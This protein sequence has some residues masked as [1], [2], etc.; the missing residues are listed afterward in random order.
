M[1]S[2]LVVDDEFLLVDL[3]SFILEEEGYAVKRANHGKMALDMI[4]ADPP[5]LV[6]TDFMM[7]LMNGLELANRLKGD[8][9]FMDIPII[10]VTGAQGT[11]ARNHPEIFAAVFDKP[12]S[13]P[14]LLDA[15]RQLIGRPG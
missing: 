15:I 9:L 1:T 6:I 11:L 5:G 4:I 10:L 3:L 7:P 14:N 2:I 13:L 8:P 12:Y